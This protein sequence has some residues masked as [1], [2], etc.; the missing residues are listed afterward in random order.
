MERSAKPPT[1]V[2]FFY[3]TPIMKKYTTEEVA[4]IVYNEGL[5]YAVQFYMSA[6]DIGNPELARE[7][8]IA[9]TALNNINNILKDYLE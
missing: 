2:R 6:K 3:Q 7:W 8:E 5:G 4:D 1:E 9:K